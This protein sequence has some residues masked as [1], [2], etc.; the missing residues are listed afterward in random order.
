MTRFR[1]APSLAGLFLSLGVAL[2]LPARSSEKPRYPL[3]LGRIRAGPKELASSRTSTVTSAHPFATEAGLEMLR[4]GGNPMDAAVA[5]TMVTGVVDYGK[6]SFA[7]GGQLTYWEARTGRTVVINHEPNA[8][9][10][11]VRPYSREREAQTGRSIRV[12]GSIAGFHLAVEKYGRRPWK[13][14]L[15][16]AIFYA[17]NGYPINDDAY[18]NM[19]EY[20]AAL[21]LRPSA[22]K[23]FAPEGFL[24]PVN[25]L[26]KQP[27][28]AATLR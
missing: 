8:V 26:F 19:R 4:R 24:P 25:S 9:R 5:A 18:A 12:P 28:M 3:D 22:R 15:E 10:E 6:T 1:F 2:T 27:E 11:D 13:E 14:V 21:T 16:P 20:Y 17:E 7:G 23:A